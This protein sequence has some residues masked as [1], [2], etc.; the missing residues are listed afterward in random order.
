MVTYF[1]KK[2][3]EIFFAFIIA[4]K[5]VKA[6]RNNSHKCIPKSA[7]TNFWYEKRGPILGEKRMYSHPT[8]NLQN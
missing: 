7:Q 4:L 8:Q 6:L 2:V 5:Y 3:E 1:F